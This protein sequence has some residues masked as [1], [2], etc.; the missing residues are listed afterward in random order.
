MSD[1]LLTPLHGAMGLAELLLDG[2]VTEAHRDY[3]ERFVAQREVLTD[4]L[5][6]LL[7]A[8]DAHDV[9]TLLTAVGICQRCVTTSSAIAPS[10][11][12]ARPPYSSS[13]VLVVDDH[14]ANRMIMG[15]FL[16]RFGITAHSAEDGRRC[17]EM[18]AETSYDLIFMD[19][20]MPGLNGIDATRAIRRNEASERRTRIVAVTA[21]SDPGIREQLLDLGMDDYL[22]KPFDFAQLEALLRKVFEFPEPTIS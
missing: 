15:R 14:A 11:P 21:L 4:R 8:I 9:P 7:A 19:V 16:Q 20:Q 1:A 22:A 10:P 5:R 17:L 13:R 3:L 12:P 18:H 2:E 6:N